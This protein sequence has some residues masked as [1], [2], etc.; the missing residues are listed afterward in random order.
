MA[1]H[2]LNNSSENFDFVLIG[3]V[4]DENQ[5]GIV[6][7]VNEALGI[8]LVLSDNVPFNLK[9]GSIFH[10]SLFRHQN[11]DLGLEIFLLPN[12]SNLEIAKAETGATGDL[13]SETG[14]EES[15]KLVKELPKTN[16]FVIVKG[17]DLHLF[18]FKIADKLKNVKEIVQLQMIEVRDLPSRMNLV[19]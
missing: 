11:E 13:F 15:T 10:F 4:T 14:V 1:K 8:D 17:E 7:K 9:P 6:S 18:K 16:Y 2:I 19:F 12:N 3:L 5:Y